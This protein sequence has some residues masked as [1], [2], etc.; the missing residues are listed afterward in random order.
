M[1]IEYGVKFPVLYGRSPLASHPTY[2]RVHMLIPNP[3]PIPHY[4]FLNKLPLFRLSPISSS[5]HLGNYVGY[6]FGKNRD[7]G[8]RVRQDKE[9]FLCPWGGLETGVYHSGLC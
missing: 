7:T 1:T 5:S 9:L 4:Y 2:L 8:V 6:S 3:E